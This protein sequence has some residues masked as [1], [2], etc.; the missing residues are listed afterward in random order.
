MKQGSLQPTKVLTT[1]LYFLIPTNPDNTMLHF[2][3]VIGS[4]SH[5]TSKKG[6][7][8]VPK[9]WDLMDPS[10][11]D[12]LVDPHVTRRIVNQALDCYSMRNRLSARGIRVL[13]NY[14]FH[15]ISFNTKL[16]GTRVQV[17]AWGNRPREWK[18]TTTFIFEIG[19]RY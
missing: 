10:D 2:P 8:R 14:N 19:E 7:Q 4:S 17:K 6:T 15:L 1:I 11:S 16:V 9:E 5:H 18:I 3:A 12:H 13:N